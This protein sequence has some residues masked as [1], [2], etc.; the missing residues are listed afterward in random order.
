MCR[1]TQFESGIHPLV[2]LGVERLSFGA[3]LS[4]RSKVR[5]LS[6]PMPKRKRRDADRA[7]PVLITALAVGGLLPHLEFPFHHVLGRRAVRLLVRSWRQRGSGV[8]SGLGGFR[9]V[10]G[11]AIWRGQ[12]DPVSAL[13]LTL[14]RCYP[15]ARPIWYH[16]ST[17]IFCNARPTPDLKLFGEPLHGVDRKNGELI[18]SG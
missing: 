4:R 6:C 14:V 15:P 16:P 17:C 1:N 2:H 10:L 18:L 8:R 11:T 3:V 7:N 12:P 13:C 5:F 9:R